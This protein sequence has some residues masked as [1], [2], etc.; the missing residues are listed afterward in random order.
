[1]SKD[2]M[3]ILKPERR[4]GSLLARWHAAAARRT[5]I[6]AVIKA[7]DGTAAAVAVPAKLQDADKR[8][9]PPAPGSQ[10]TI[11]GITYRVLYTASTYMEESVL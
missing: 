9:N 3:A 4:P 8:T 6:T 11:G 10:L 2:E 7:P 5:Y 1:M